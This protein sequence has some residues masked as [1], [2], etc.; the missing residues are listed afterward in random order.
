MLV[1][2]DK[3]KWVIYVFL[4]SLFLSSCKNSSS[5]LKKFFTF[6]GDK[7]ENPKVLS[8]TPGNGDKGLPQNQKIGV[9]FNKPMNINAC[10]QSFSILTFGEWFF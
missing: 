6:L 4:L 10:I 1:R 3:V 7:E 8:S 9:I 5:D 2:S